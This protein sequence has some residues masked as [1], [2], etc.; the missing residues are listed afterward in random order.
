MFAPLAFALTSS[1]GTIP[2]VAIVAGA[3]VSLVGPSVAV[4][5]LRSQHAFARDEADRDEV[6]G[7]LDTIVEHIYRAQM[8]ILEMQDLA[9]S[10]GEHDE[11]EPNWPSKTGPSKRALTGDRITLLSELNRLGLR[12][13][14]VADPMIDEVVKAT[15]IIARA[16]D[17]TDGYDEAAVAAEELESLHEEIQ[18]TRLAFSDHAIKFTRAHTRGGAPIVLVWRAG[19]RLILRLSEWHGARS[20]RRGGADARLRP[21]I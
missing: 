19:E 13:A 8:T 18:D 11:P 14:A 10:A 1:S 20:H 3:V 15:N 16:L 4:W 12:L 2:I 5:T 6:K 17:L 7:I 21:P 9:E